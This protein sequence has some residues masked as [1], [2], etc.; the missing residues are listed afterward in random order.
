MTQAK[1]NKYSIELGEDF[2]LAY[3]PELDPKMTT[4]IYES[5][6]CTLTVTDWT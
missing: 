5:D 6:V 1:D 2:E 4:G 3:W